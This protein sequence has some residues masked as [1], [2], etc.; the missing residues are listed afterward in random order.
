[1]ISCA[2]FTIS[3][4]IDDHPCDTMS[5]IWY[6]MIW[7]DMIWY[8]MGF[9]FCVTT[10]ML[11]S[12][13]KILTTRR[14]PLYMFKWYK[15]STYLTMRCFGFPKRFLPNKMRFAIFVPSYSSVL[16]LC[17]TIIVKGDAI[18]YFKTWTNK[19]K[20]KQNKT[21]KQPPQNRCSYTTLFLL[22]LCLWI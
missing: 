16:S 17:F 12:I 8:D 4:N 7:Y 3:L 1:M 13:S 10:D 11:Y 15:V 6:D 20:T 2:T 18:I 9:E 14:S 21:N 5:L 19:N 22:C